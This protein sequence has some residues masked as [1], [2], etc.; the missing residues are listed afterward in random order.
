MTREDE[1]HFSQ[2]HEPDARLK[3][4]TKEKI[5]KKVKNGQMACAVAF[6]IAEELEISAAQIGVALDLM[7]IKLMK[8]QLGLFGYQPGE[9]TVTPKKPEVPGLAEAI[10][11]ARVDGKLS[12]R[13]A[14]D[15]AH[16]FKVRKMTI[17]AACDALKIKMDSCQ[18]GAF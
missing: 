3:P 2:K 18:L 11:A 13:N 8:C 1:G 16:K 5:E 9:K 15:L 4:T 10:E 17:S 14:W 6:Q 12:C 7:E